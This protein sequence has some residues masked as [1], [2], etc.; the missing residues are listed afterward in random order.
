MLMFMSVYAYQDTERRFSVWYHW[1]A[2]ARSRAVRIM[3]YSGTQAVR[4][5][6]LD[7]ETGV[8]MTLAATLIQCPPP[9]IRVTHVGYGRALWIGI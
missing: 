1:R 2:T 6:G 5:R 9:P 7:H 4:W 3:Y 8:H